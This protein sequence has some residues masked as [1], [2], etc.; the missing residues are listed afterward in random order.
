[1]TPKPIRFPREA[2][3]FWRAL[4]RAFSRVSR[5][6]RRDAYELDHWSPASKTRAAL[7]HRNLL[8]AERVYAAFEQEKDRRVTSAKR[9][10]QEAYDRF[11]GP[12]RY[13]RARG[14]FVRVDDDG[15]YKTGRMVNGVPEVRR[16]PCEQ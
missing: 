5:L 15:F 9:S 8:E 14:Q 7:V 11:V 1:V 4:Y 16:V 12:N 13:R 3:A 6:R 10:G 2:A